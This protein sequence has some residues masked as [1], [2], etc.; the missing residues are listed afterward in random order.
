[1]STDH[2]IPGSLTVTLIGPDELRRK[3]VAA[4]LADCNVGAMRE[5]TSYPTNLE[6]LP[7]MLAKHYDVILVDLDSDPEYALD[8]LSLIH[9]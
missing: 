1:M 4:A 8:V 6:E 7:E 3:A 2:E 9:I 5:F